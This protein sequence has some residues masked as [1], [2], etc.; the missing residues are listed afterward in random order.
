[1]TLLGF[2]LSWVAFQANY[3]AR[4]MFA[5][6]GGSSGFAGAEAGSRVGVL[7]ASLLDPAGLRPPA[8]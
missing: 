7:L 5:R 1:M 6:F 4:V 8:N 3:S 2:L